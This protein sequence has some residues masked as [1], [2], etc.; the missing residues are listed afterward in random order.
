MEC[1]ESFGLQ[2]RSSIRKPDIRSTN[3]LITTKFAHLNFIEDNVDNK[4]CANFE[5]VFK[6]HVCFQWLIVS[7]FGSCSRL[8]E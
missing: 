2:V 7:K 8:E 5:G 3:C 4:N 1:I 6:L